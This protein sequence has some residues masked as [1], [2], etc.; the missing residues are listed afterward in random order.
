MGVGN[1]YVSCFSCFSCCSCFPAPCLLYFPLFSVF[2]LFIWLWF[3][4]SQFF[5]KFVL[6]FLLLPPLGFHRFYIVDFIQ[7]QFPFSVS[8]SSSSLHC[9]E[10]EG[11]EQQKRR[12]PFL[13]LSKKQGLM[14]AKF[15]WK[16]R[17]QHSV[18]NKKPAAYNYYNKY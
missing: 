2:L 15:F 12:G 18:M 3:Y 16:C 5:L 8:V 11:G 7:F 17:Y 14:C 6:L 13:V 1:A 10:K 4:F 9:K